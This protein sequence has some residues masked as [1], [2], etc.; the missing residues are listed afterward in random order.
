MESTTI[1]DKIE[2]TPKVEITITKIVTDF[3]N[4]IKNIEDESKKTTTIENKNK[5]IK[6]LLKYIKSIKKDTISL[7]KKKKPK[8]KKVKNP[9]SLSGLEK[10]KEIMPEF[11]KF[12]NLDKNECSR[13]EVTKLCCAYIKAHELQN[14]TNRTEI[15]IDQPLADILKFDINNPTKLKYS[16]LQKYIT[17]VFVPQV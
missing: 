4:L 11:K 3:D 7:D 9:N 10:P 2:K 12:F 6:S 13:V 17:N 14:T 16:T 15:N 8:I 5:Y 1:D